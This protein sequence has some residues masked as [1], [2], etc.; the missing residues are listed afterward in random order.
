MERRGQIQRHP[1][2]DRA[3]LYGEIYP[4]ADVFVMPSWAEGFGFTNVEALSFGLPVI[5]SRLGSIAEV[6]D[7]GATGFLVPSGDV[8]AVSLAMERFAAD[9]SLVRRM[10]EAARAAFLAR[11]TLERFQAGV[12]R[13]YQE[14]LET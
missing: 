10:G 9:R 2:Q 14:A 6:I 5:S 11:F 13:V 1:L 4:M 12:G 8:S 7:D 3:R